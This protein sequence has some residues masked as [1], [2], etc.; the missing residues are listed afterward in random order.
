M[1]INPQI[2]NPIDFIARKSRKRRE[3]DI[4]KIV[5]D[6]GGK[7]APDSYRLDSG[8]EPGKRF[9]GYIR[10]DGA[11]VLSADDKVDVTDVYCDMFADI[12]N[13]EEIELGFFDL[14][15]MTHTDYMFSGCHSLRKIYDILDI[16]KAE[17]ASSMFENCYSLERVDGIITGSLIHA[18][19]MFR[20]C[21]ELSSC[22]NIG[23]KKKAKCS[24]NEMFSSCENLKEACLINA[25]CI[26]AKEMFMNCSSLQRVCFADGGITDSVDINAEKAFRNCVSLSEIFMDNWFTNAKGKQ[27][28]ENCRSLY[29]YKHSF[30]SAFDSSLYVSTPLPF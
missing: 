26:N 12:C 16:Q 11:L 29:G 27:T 9:Y 25:D 4:K 3:E 14:S 6:I 21:W 20:N 7:A 10:E 15:E 19:R 17:S 5:W 2:G 30:T 1:K 22:Q 13:C 23:F 24:C 18:E 8:E 28:F